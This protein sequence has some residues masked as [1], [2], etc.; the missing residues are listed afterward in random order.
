MQ[1]H[2]ETPGALQH[3]T[4]ALAQGARLSQAPHQACLANGVSILHLGENSTVS[5]HRWPIPPH[6]SPKS[7]LTDSLCLFRL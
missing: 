1:S 3:I 5:L 4:C 7:T 2:L 6:Y